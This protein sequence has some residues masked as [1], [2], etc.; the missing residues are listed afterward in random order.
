MAAGRRSQADL[1]YMEDMERL[2]RI[3]RDEPLED[4]VIEVDIDWWRFGCFIVFLTVTLYRCC[5]TSMGR[6]FPFRLC[7]CPWC[8][9]RGE[10]AEAG[11]ENGNTESQCCCCCCCCARR[12]GEQPAAQVA[13]SGGEGNGGFPALLSQVKPKKSVLT[14]YIVFFMAG[15]TG[16][17]HFY[18]DRL[19]HGVMAVCSMNFFLL[20]WCLD[21]LL[22]PWYVKGA[23]QST[24]DC[25]PTDTGG[26]RLLCRLPVISSAALAVFTA[27]FIQTPTFLNDLGVVDIDAHLAR[28]QSNPYELLGVVHGA[29]RNV[30]D[31]ALEERM[32]ELAKSRV[33][34][35]KPRGKACKDK[36]EQLSRAAAYALRQ[37]TPVRQSASH[38]RDRRSSRKLPA[39]YDDSWA[40]RLSLQWKALLNITKESIEE[41][42]QTYFQQEP[43]EQDSAQSSSS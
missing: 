41:G 42:I 6:R 40:G 1:A 38:R 26:L 4:D 24:A 39:E 34:L 18:L 28:T 33:C 36:Q 25:A 10:G 7:G 37:V 27:F 23:N 3:S 11:A 8:A 15:I 14:A 16:A 17:H 9:S 5:C 35:E 20:G 2:K 22:M 21:A 12:A 19:V 31:Q 30:V 29:P 13:V 32:K 43:G